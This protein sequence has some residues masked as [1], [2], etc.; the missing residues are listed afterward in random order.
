MLK[1]RDVATLAGTKLASHK[2]WTSLFVVLE[3]I[4]LAAVLLLFSGIHGLEGSLATFNSEGLNGKYL[5]YASN[6]RANPS[7]ED[8]PD[9]WDL[10]EELYQEVVAERTALAEEYGVSYSADS[11]IAPTEYVDGEREANPASPYLTEA[12]DQRMEGYLEA[13]LTDLEAILQN[14]PY[15]KIYTLQPLNADGQVT[16]LV[17]GQEDLD[18]YSLSSAEGQENRIFTGLNVVDQTLYQDYLF[19]GITV[20][21]EAIPVV[22]SAESAATLLGL[23]S[24]PSDSVEKIAYLQ[25]LESKAAGLVVE[26]CYRNGASIQQIYQAEQILSELDRNADSEFFTR[27]SLIYALPNA[28]CGAVTIAEDARTEVEIG[29]AQR[30]EAFERALGTYSAPVQRRVKFQVVG[31]IP[32]SDISTGGNDII[33]MIQSLGGVSLTTPLVAQDYYDAHQAELAQIYGGND[34]NLDYLGL[35]TN[36]IVEFADADTAREFIANESCTPQGTLN[37]GC[38]TPEHLF[39]LTASVNNS[40]LVEDL[41]QSLGQVLL[42]TTVVVLV[43]TVV[44]VALMVVRSIASDR[45][46]IAIF[47]AIG[48]T[49]GWILQIYLT[50]ALIMALMIVAGAVVVALVVG[51]AFNPWLSGALTEFLSATFSTTNAELAANVFTPQPLVWLALCGGVIGVSL[52]SGLLA[53]ALKNHAKIID[54][55]RYE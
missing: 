31:V 50:Y 36:Y 32:T 16:N 30:Q 47:R 44:L 14:Y 45:K 4:L 21:A 20:D 48:F 8:D 51:L 23:G 17:D 22:V 6:A 29:Q 37:N 39:Y 25:D 9:T 40:L 2:L 53:I 12:I 46:E 26:A 34:A 35:G 15:Q 18:S 43:V 33:S 27:S 49:R 38:A 52:V 1:L 42:V 10:A 13:D 19:D 24:V 55:L 11:E 41:S 5:V 7:L 54:G 3:V 28:A